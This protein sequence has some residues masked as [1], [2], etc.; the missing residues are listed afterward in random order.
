MTDPAAKGER[1]LAVSGDFLSMRDIA[2]I[3]K[4]RLGAAARRV[5][6]LQL[7]NFMVRLAALRDPAVKQIVPE[8]GKPK[9]A[10][11]GKA[12][13]L[14]GWSPRSNEEAIV[15]TARSLVRLGLLKDGKRAQAAA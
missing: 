4:A 13:R 1:F 14:L 9:N 7:P 2:R 11:S 5:P 15:A 10:S 6:T 3:L 8:L 12:R